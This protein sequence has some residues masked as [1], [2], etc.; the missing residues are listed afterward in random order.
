MLDALNRGIPL[1]DF[2]KSWN[3]KDAV[4]AIHSSWAEVSEST[5]KNG[6]HQLCPPP[7]EVDSEEEEPVYENALIP[8]EETQMLENMRQYIEN[9]PT[10]LFQEEEL[11]DILNCDI[12]EPVTNSMSDAEIAEA[13]LDRGEHTNEEDSYYADDHEKIHIDD[14]VQLCDKLIIGLE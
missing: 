4:Y 12:D 9:A 2:L 6:W 11:Q 3:V 10:S 5:L 7:T 14:L 13:A 8:V 1:Q